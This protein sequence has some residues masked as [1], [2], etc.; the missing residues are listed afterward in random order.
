MTSGGQT[1]YPISTI[2][3]R[4]L[5]GTIGDVYIKDEVPASKVVDGR[6][7]TDRHTHRHTHTQRQTDMT[8]YMIVA[9][10]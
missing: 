2:F 6:V 5:E 1:P 8:N 3:N 9:H 10:L 7:V 4:L